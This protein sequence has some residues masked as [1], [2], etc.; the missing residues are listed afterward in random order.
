[1]MRNELKVESL[2][3]I[4]CFKKENITASGNGGLDFATHLTVVSV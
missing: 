3:S 2:R 1:M 4:N